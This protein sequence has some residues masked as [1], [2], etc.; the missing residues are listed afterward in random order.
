M[1]TL[2]ELF[3]SCQIEKVVSYLKFKPQKIIFIGFSDDDFTEKYNAIKKMIQ[4]QDRTV[5]LAYIAVSRYNYKDI[6]EKLET[7]LQ[8]NANCFFDLTGGKELVLV[9]MGAISTK[10]RIPMCQIDISTNRL[11]PISCFE[12]LP[13][14]HIKSLTLLDSITLNCGILEQSAA[15][16]IAHNFM[17]AVQCLWSSAKTNSSLWNIQTKALITFEKIFST[18]TDRFAVTCNPDDFNTESKSFSILF[19][20]LKRHGL[21]AVEQ[22]REL[23]RYRYKNDSVRHFL[24]KFGNILESYTYSVMKSIEQGYSDYIHDVS[25]QVS[26]RWLDG[27]QASNISNEI[28]VAFMCGNI[29]AFISCKSGRVDKNA[30]YELNTVATRLGGKYAKKFLIVTDINSSLPAKRALLSRAKK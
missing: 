11:I 10:Y 21:I 9:A 1:Y 17:E 20:A 14:E 30:L 5:A 19:G 2:I 6:I 28:D 8:N 13:K 25:M 23:I 16:A 15:P 24:E 3:D 4:E 18:V 27:G 29:P 7:I 22:S 12:N 26:V